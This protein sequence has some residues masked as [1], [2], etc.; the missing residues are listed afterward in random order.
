VLY[1]DK[2]VVGV[3]VRFRAPLQLASN[4]SSISITQIA[5]QVVHQNGNRNAFMNPVPIKWIES[6]RSYSTSDKKLQ[7]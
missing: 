1:R 2:K 6:I 4:T 7:S 5:A 3:F